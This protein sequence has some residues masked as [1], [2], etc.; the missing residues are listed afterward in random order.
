M[1]NL[2][3]PT[4]GQAGTSYELRTCGGCEV[5]S[6][7]MLGCS[8]CGERWCCGEACER[9]A[10]EVHGERCAFLTPGERER[11]RMD[12]IAEYLAEQGNGRGGGGGW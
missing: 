1:A 6:L 10:W 7:Y 2:F 3:G 4:P 9:R 5:R 11:E 12:A 8:S